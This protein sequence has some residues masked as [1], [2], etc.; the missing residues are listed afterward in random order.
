M[1]GIEASGPHVS[2]RLDARSA[3]GPAATPVGP[4]PGMEE[5]YCLREVRTRTF[6][7]GCSTDVNA[8]TTGETPDRGIRTMF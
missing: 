6:S 1:N 7:A 8:A 5:P 4:R 2:T 3:K